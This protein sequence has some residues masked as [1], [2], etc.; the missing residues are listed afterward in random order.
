MAQ[1]CSIKVPERARTYPHAV[2]SRYL[3]RTITWHR[4]DRQGAVVI[5]WQNFPVILPFVLA[6]RAC[7]QGTWLLLTQ[8]RSLLTQQTILH[9]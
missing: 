5:L 7:T 9:T 1:Y 6:T 2:D 8:E 4:E 3:M